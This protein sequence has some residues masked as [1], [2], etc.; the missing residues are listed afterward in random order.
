MLYDELYIFSLILINDDL[1]YV[2]SRIFFLKNKSRIFEYFFTSNWYYICVCV[3]IYYK[4]EYFSL[5]I[6]LK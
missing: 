5:D 1:L 3:Y 4:Y 2:F 6:L